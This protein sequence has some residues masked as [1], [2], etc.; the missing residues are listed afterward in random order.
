MIQLH[1]VYI[2]IIII[3]NYIILKNI[4]K[5]YILP[6]YGRFSRARS[7]IIIVYMYKPDWKWHAYKEGIC[8]V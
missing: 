3:I 7:H 8:M 1:C 5:K 4:Y 2:I 6:T